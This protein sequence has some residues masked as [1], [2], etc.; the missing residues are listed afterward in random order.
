[1]TIFYKK[2]SLDSLR[3]GQHLTT[4]QS[5]RLLTLVRNAI[6]NWK[7]F[8]FKQLEFLD[9][10]ACSCLLTVFGENESRVKK[11]LFYEEKT[12]VDNYLGTSNTN[13]K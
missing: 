1:M 2:K 7:N 8:H 11:L 9:L 13:N 12:A 5:V 3:T 10:F 6:G 4:C